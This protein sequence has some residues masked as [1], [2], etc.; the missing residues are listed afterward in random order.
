MN[1][2]S[3]AAQAGFNKED[4]GKLEIICPSLIEQDDIIAILHKVESVI[5]NRQLE[6]AYLDNFIKSRFVEMFGNTVTNSLGW[7]DHRLDEYIDFL[8]SGSRGWAQYFVDEENEFGGLAQEI[9][10]EGAK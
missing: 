3:R 9:P 10:N 6:L 2:G 5:K 8:T 4:L 1:V 7:E